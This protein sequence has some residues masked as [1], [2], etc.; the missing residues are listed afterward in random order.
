[1]ATLGS[2]SLQLAFILAIAGVGVAIYARLQ[3]REDL[4]E[5]ANR[6][7]IG[8]GILITVAV[9]V[10][11]RELFL[12]NFQIEY[13]AQY[14]SRNTPWNYKLT[15]LWAGQDGSL[16]FW[17][18]ILSIYAVV[19][20]IQNRKRNLNLLP[21]AVAVIL[22]VQVFFLI[23]NNFIADPFQPVP[24]GFTIPD[25]QGLNPQLQNPG[26]MIHPPMLYLG[27]IGFTIPFAFAMSAMLTGKLDNLWI[28]ST[29]RWTLFAWLCLSIGITLGG[30]WAYVELGWGGYWAWDPVENASFM[31]W[32]TGTAFLHSVI[33]QE[34]KNMLRVWNMVL[35]MLTFFLSIFG[36]FLTRSGVISSVHSFTASS[37]GPFFSGFLVII[38]LSS[39]FLLYKRMDILKTRNKLESLSSRESSFLLNNLI[40]IGICF[41]VLWGTM[42]PLVSEAVR[43]SKIT[44]G[45]PFFN[46]VNVPIGLALLLLTGI[47]P[48]LAWR[49]TSFESFKRNFM[50]PIVLGGIAAIVLWIVGVRDLYPFISGVLIV[51]VSSS[52]I[53]EFWK[54]TTARHR[55][56]G[57]NYARALVNIVLKNKSRFGGYIVHL[58]IVFYFIGFTGSAFNVEV[59]KTIEP[60][61]AIEAGMFSFVYSDFQQIDRPN[62]V[63]QIVELK[64]LKNGKSYGKLYPEKRM[65]FRSNQPNTE[66]DIIQTWREDLYATLA[67]VSGGENSATIR[68][69]V[70]PLVQWIWIGG[71]ILAF[72]TIIAMLPTKPRTIRKT[73]D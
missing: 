6:A 69:F 18:W 22:V 16:L 43:G 10:L 19:A 3:R 53:Q 67:G 15:A 2:I 61:E 72:G 26:M 25:G 65:Y 38:I 24:P 66:V 60:G 32:L 44:V 62:H 57:E 33:I 63:A 14:T 1:M 7:V 70:N 45:P 48:L 27:Y 64:V 59:E 73:N 23:L 54:G 49:R 42:F 55:M 37:I 4:M 34:K 68:I 28:T 17:N 13:V 71:A 51:F 9:A 21:Y 36:T 5:T 35:I 39:V 30:K 47:G 58:A 40:F 46:Q 20:V 52:I 56:T 50:T 29:R 11:L 31:P 41:S 8:V 12:S